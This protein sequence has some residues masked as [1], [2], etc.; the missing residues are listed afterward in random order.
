MHSEYNT[1]QN[2]YKQLKQ[3]IQERN[4]KFQNIAEILAEYLESLKLANSGL[5]KEERSVTINLQRI[6]TTPAE[7]LTPVDKATIVTILLKQI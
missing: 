2:D 4:K 3:R 5:L 1:L 6:L 7:R